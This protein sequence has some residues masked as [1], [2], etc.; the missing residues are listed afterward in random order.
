MC[1]ENN[2]RR[3]IVLFSSHIWEE[4]NVGEERSV[5]ENEGEEKQII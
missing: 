2:R 3:D 1:D 5:S 4:G